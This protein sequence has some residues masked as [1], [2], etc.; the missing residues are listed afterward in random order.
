VGAII[1]PCSQYSNT[2]LSSLLL[3]SS[4]S[5]WGRGLSPV[6]SLISC[7][8]T[9][10][11]VTQVPTQMSVT[12][13]G[14]KGMRQRLMW[15]DMS[16]PLTLHQY[17]RQLASL[18][19]NAANTAMFTVTAGDYSDTRSE[20]PSSGVHASGDCPGIERVFTARNYQLR[21]SDC[22]G[23]RLSAAVHQRVPAAAGQRRRGLRAVPA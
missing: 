16:W 18:W 7:W 21:H 17:V 8:F 1:S 20:R 5:S 15:M 12:L 14:W 6:T 23:R 2:D 13:G 3:S 9:R 19:V 11:P 10:A 22:Q 4:L